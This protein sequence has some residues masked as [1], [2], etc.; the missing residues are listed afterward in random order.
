MYA[1]MICIPLK[2]SEVSQNDNTTKHIYQ[3][4]QIYFDPFIQGL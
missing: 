2:P 3:Y 1:K 4:I